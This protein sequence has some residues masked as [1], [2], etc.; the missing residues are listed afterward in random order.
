MATALVSC[1]TSFMRRDARLDLVHLAL[2]MERYRLDHGNLP[3]QLD[4][5]V[6]EYLE[7]VPM[8]IYDGQPLRYAPQEEGGYIVYS[9]SLNFQ[10][11]GGAPLAFGEREGDLSFRVAR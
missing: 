2:A 8:D 5:L 7:S 6:G 3:A 11:D 1:L 10:D 4:D 9:V